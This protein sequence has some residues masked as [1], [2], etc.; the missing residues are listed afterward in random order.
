MLILLL[1]I[2]G[3]FEKQYRKRLENKQG[4]QTS[5]DGSI[6]LQLMEDK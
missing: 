6:K 5:D 2:F 3:I 1:N 4:S